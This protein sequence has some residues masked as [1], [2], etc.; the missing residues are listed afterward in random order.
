ML[1]RIFIKTSI[2]FFFIIFFLQYCT[3]QNHLAGRI[4]PVR[5][6]DP[7]R[8][9]YVWHPWSSPRCP[10]VLTAVLAERSLKLLVFR[11]LRKQCIMIRSFDCTWRI[12]R[13]LIKAFCFVEWQCKKLWIE[14]P[15]L[16]R[17]WIFR[18]HI[19]VLIF[20]TLH[21]LYGGAMWWGVNSKHWNIEF[22][23]F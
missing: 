17:W 5:G 6:P 12:G 19:H 15:F 21:H 18:T 1:G 11:E 10:L 2:I 13:M 3:S 14:V 22:I 8:G 4:K 16:F 7:A 23:L 20:L 9:P